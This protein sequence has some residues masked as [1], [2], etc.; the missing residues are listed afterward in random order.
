MNKINAW[1]KKYSWTAV[2]VT[3]VFGFAACDFIDPTKVENPQTT[4]ENLR[5]NGKGA[6]T[7]FLVGVQERFSDAVEDLITFTDPVSDNYDNTSTFISPQADFPADIR[8][9][10]LTLDGNIG[11]PFFETQELR[12]LVEFA[13]Q[14]V[15]PNDPDATNEQR[16]ELLFYRGMASLLLAENFAGAPIE[17][18]GRALTPAE[19]IQLTIRDFQQALTTSQHNG[20]VTRLYLAAARAYRLAGDAAN[21]NALADAAIA[22]GPA[23]FVFFA[24]YDA[25]NNTNAGWTF[26]VSR[27]TADLQPLPRLDFLDPKYIENNTPIPVLKMEEA[28]LIKAEAALSLG[29]VS[30]ATQY[31]GEAINLAKNRPTAAFADRDPRRSR[32]QGGVAQASP[33]AA[34]VDGLILARG[35]AVVQ[36]H[37]IS[38][39]SLDAGAVASLNDPTEILRT[40]YLARQEIFYYESRR[41]SD[42]GIRL[43][44]MN[45]EIGTNPAVNPGDPGTFVIVPGYIP[46]G[47][48]LDRFTANG[49][50]TIIESDLNQILANNRV[51]PFS[52]PF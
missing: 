40:L 25:E 37:L 11:S 6:T 36:A 39:T 52:L 15:V 23:D 49:N 41:M 16:A 21:A 13:L 32:P 34:P 5:E 19:H 30:G 24:Q 10:D 48:G 33:N 29:N 2:G 27:G 26:A 43:P 31:L 14:E 28:H 1:L 20:F 8:P 46:A 38:G 9:D 47:D 4:D 42:L 3:M 22:S 17:E 7:P 35:G 44:M 12:A 18:N 50:A 45:R 51:S